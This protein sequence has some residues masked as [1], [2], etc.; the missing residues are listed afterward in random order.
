MNNISANCNILEV[1]LKYLSEK[2]LITI[3]GGGWAYDAGRAFMSFILDDLPNWEQSAGSRS[4]S[5]FQH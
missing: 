1:D 4:A 5:Y 2:E 3:D